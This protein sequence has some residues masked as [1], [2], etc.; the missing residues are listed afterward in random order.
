MFRELVLLIASPWVTDRPAPGV[1]RE[2]TWGLT[3]ASRGGAGRG[4]ETES[5]EVTCLTPA[6]LGW[7]LQP[8]PLPTEYPWLV[9]T[10][11]RVIT[12]LNRD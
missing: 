7:S 1:R 3:R 2:H 6:S 4:V 11:L 12:W 9:G 8:Q 5:P 10:Y